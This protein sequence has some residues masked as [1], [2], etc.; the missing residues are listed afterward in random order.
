M[1]HRLKHNLAT[2]APLLLLWVLLTAGTCPVWA[3]DALEV[4]SEGGPYHLCHYAGVLQDPGGRLGIDQVS[5]PPFNLQFKNVPGHFLRMGTHKGAVW[6]RLPLN[7][8]P[9]S[10]PSDWVLELS[11]EFV[12]RIDLYLPNSKGGWSAIQAGLSRPPNPRMAVSRIPALQLPPDLPRQA[13][14][15]I[16]LQSRFGLGMHILL[17]NLREFHFHT[18]LD[19]SFYGLLYGAPLAMALFNFFV[20]LSLRDRIYV[21]YVVFILCMLAY[22]VLLHGQTHML[23]PLPHDTLLTLFGIMSGAALLFGV[24]FSRAFLLTSINAPL[25]DKVLFAYMGLALVRIGMSLAGLHALGNHLT[26]IMGLASPVLSITTG[27]VCWRRGFSPARYYIVAWTVLSL[28]VTWHV[29][30]SLSLLP[31]TQ[32]SSMIIGVGSALESILLSFALADRIRVLRRERESLVKATNH[33]RQLSNRDA[34]TG[35][36]N[37][38]YFRDRLAPMA[39]ETQAQD[40]P[41]FLIMADIDNF[42]KFNDAHGHP[43]GDKVLEGMG[44]TIG[45]CVRHDDLPCRYGGEEFAVILPGASQDQGRAV[46]ERIR[47][48]FKALRFKPHGIPAAPVTVSLGLA[49]L[50]GGESAEALLNRADQALYT[51]KGRGKN[52]IVMDP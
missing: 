7:F 49:T 41:L 39:V 48:E 6:L 15:Y 18:L 24:Q 14:I 50:H 3:G 26:Q 21:Y 4:T 13:V 51:A 5:S 45:H 2:A 43:E 29:L 25:W 47:R 37:L 19:S 32:V 34:L 12:D 42:K 44:Q 36:Y 27:V 28:C 23:V 35:L 9:G 40:E 38:R 8:A 33:Y 1:L 30:V 20:F 46:A 31:W 17:R 10:D 52:Q 22:Q 11:K 16:R